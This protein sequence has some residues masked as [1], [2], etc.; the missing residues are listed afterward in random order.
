MVSFNGFFSFSPSSGYRIHVVAVA[1]VDQSEMRRRLRMQ[2][3]NN[4][5]NNNNTT[6]RG[7]VGSV[8][9]HI[10][11]LRKHVCSWATVARYVLSS[12]LVGRILHG[13]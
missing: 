7:I 2:Y 10:E 6:Y 12:V 13:S 8:Q 11:R 5:N 4:N 9:T 3:N 1:R